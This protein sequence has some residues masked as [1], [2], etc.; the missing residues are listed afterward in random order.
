MSNFTK[1]WSSC[2]HHK[3]QNPM[4][5]I[6]FYDVENLEIRQKQKENKMYLNYD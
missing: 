4:Q 1:E 5:K 3:V 6:K 2:K